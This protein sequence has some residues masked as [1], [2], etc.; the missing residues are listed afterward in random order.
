MVQLP[1]LLPA[2]KRLR[3]AQPLKAAKVPEC[4]WAIQ[5][6][7]VP[8]PQS[9]M[10]LLKKWRR[11]LQNRQQKARRNNHDLPDFSGLKKGSRQRSFFCA[12]SGANYIN[13]GMVITV[14]R[15]VPGTLLEIPLRAISFSP[16]VAI[17]PGKSTGLCQP[18]AARIGGRILWFRAE[19]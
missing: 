3:R 8:P 7:A 11:K 5:A 17:R 1:K 12:C 6:P 4:L 15:K 14:F 18:S 9:V 13:G 16:P 2:R 10:P 19:L